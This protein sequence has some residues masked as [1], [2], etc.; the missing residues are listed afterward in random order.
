M[1]AASRTEPYPDLARRRA[2]LT[3]LLG[4]IVDR[5]RELAAA[6]DADFGGR[7]VEETLQAEILTSITYLKHARRHL[8][9]WIAPH[10]RGI[11]IKYRFASNRVVYQPL[12]VVGVI[13]PWNYPVRSEERR[14]GKEWR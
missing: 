13:A 12:G 4:A 6:I 1:R 5:K 9:R 8:A 11:A 14:V 10:R 3:R 7:S 2:M